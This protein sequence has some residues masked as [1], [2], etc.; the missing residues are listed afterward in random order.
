[1]SSSD[2]EHEGEVSNECDKEH[3][4]HPGKYAS[5]TEY[6]RNA[7]KYIRLFRSSIE[8]NTKTL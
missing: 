2:D 7:W 4:D 3:D 8:Y 1:M 6:E 5:F